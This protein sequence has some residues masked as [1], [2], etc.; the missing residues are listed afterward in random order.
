VYTNSVYRKIF[1]YNRWESVKCCIKGLGRMDLVHI[2][3]F[4]TFKFW[5]SLRQS[6]NTT[7]YNTFMCFS[8]ERDY[9]VLLRTYSC[10]ITDSIGILKCKVLEHYSS[11]CAAREVIDCFF[12]FLYIC[13][14]FVVYLFITIIF[15]GP[16]AQSRSPQA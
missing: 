8:R 7:L 9:I 4:Q 10:T 11:V 12:S 5:K 3:A 15:W 6:N 2:L 13:V 14:P 1:L 16:P